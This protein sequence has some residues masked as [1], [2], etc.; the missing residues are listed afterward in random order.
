MRPR[1]SIGLAVL[2]LLLCAHAT[3]ARGAAHTAS[4][5][6]A[7]KYEAERALWT[8]FKS[9]IGESGDDDRKAIARLPPPEGTTVV[10][11]NVE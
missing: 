4:A 1:P 6:F 7:T 8:Y 9:E 5:K 10:V 11:G 2:G 3:P